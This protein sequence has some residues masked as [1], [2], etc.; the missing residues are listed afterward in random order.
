MSEVYC[1]STG[2]EGQ[3]SLSLLDK[4]FKVD[5]SRQQRGVKIVKERITFVYS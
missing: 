2:T 1:F 5:R 4:M 3:K